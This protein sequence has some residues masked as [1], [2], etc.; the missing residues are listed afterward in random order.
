[1]MLKIK[2]MPNVILGKPIENNVTKA[3]VII[4]ESAKGAE[5]PKVEIVAVGEA[6]RGLNVGDVVYYAP[7]GDV[8]ILNIQGD[9]Y[10]QLYG[11]YIVGKD[12]SV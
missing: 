10:I 2:P 11:D 5:V 6:I 1:M 12:E 9:R 7:M 8:P 4:P 3:G